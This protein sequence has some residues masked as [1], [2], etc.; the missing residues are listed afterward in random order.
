MRAHLICQESNQL[1]R[2]EKEKKTRAGLVDQSES[3]EK[4]VSE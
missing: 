4:F 2:E 3:K 1:R